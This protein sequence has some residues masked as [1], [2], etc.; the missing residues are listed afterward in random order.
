MDKK[1]KRIVSFLIYIAAAVLVIIFFNKILNG[2][3]YEV[4]GDT[5][6]YYFPAEYD[7]GIIP[8]NEIR[9]KKRDG[10]T[11]RYSKKYQLLSINGVD[12]D[13][14]VTIGAQRN[15]LGR[16]LSGGYF[17]NGKLGVVMYDYLTSDRSA[18]RYYLFF[19]FYEE[20]GKRLE[21]AINSCAETYAYDIS[22]SIKEH[23]GDDDIQCIFLSYK[24]DDVNQSYIRIRTATEG[25]VSDDPD[26]NIDDYPEVWLLSKGNVNCLAMLRAIISSA[27]VD[28]RDEILQ[29]V[30]EG[31]KEELLNGEYSE[32]I[33]KTD[34]FSVEIY[35]YGI[36]K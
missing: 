30:S 21:D 12:I 1:R 29:K 18:I 35:G 28:M 3:N 26:I 16:Y 8:F 23:I 19:N 33:N 7:T 15:E 10:V 20:D 9:S 2:T 5:V 6:Y 14:K 25:Y 4:E 27:G 24:Q 11:V 34:D 13:D 32:N 17:D 22:E 36:K 31:I